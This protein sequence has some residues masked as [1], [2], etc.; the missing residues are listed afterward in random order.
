[1]RTVDLPVRARSGEAVS[2]IALTVLAPATIE[3]STPVVFAYPGGNYSRAY[4]DICLPH[5]AGY[6]KAQHHVS[7]GIVLI[8]VDHPGAGQSSAL[9]GSVSVEVLGELHAAAVCETLE[10]FALGAI[11]GLGQ[12][13]PSIVI[14]LGH[15]R[16]AAILTVQRQDSER[17]TPWRCLAGARSRRAYRPR[18]AA[19]LARGYSFG[20]RTTGTMNHPMSPMRIRRPGVPRTVG[21]SGIGEAPPGRCPKDGGNGSRARGCG[22][23]CFGVSGIRSGG[24]S[25]QNPGW[26]K[27]TTLRRPCVHGS[28]SSSPHA[29]L[30]EH[31]RVALGEPRCVVS[32]ESLTRGTA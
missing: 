15:S 2:T 28:R 29:Q 21:C 19:R 8:A 10:R 26:A 22:N 7:R 32:S 20:G 11:A 9:E 18:K 1:M 14:G 27:S 16:G 25:D 23:R 24:M 5:R 4:Y 31:T 6:S 17:S 30:R 3:R 13:H 12:L